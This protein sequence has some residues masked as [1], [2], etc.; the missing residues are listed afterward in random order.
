MMKGLAQPTGSMSSQ[1]WVRAY[2]RRMA[3]AVLLTTVLWYLYACRTLGLSPLASS[4]ASSE[5]KQDYDRIL[6]TGVNSA[7]N[8]TLGFSKIFAIGLPERSDKRDALSL[9]AALTGFH[10]EW[11]DGVR[12]ESIPD[13]ALPYGTSRDLPY[14]GNNGLGCW[15]SHMNVVRK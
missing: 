11:V 4:S 7:A 6:A 10:V 13:R 3:A 2:K 1:S 9:I 12:G 5:N 15:R 14:L 8:D